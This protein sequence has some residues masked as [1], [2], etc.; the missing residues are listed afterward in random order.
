ML[1]RLL[2]SVV[3]KGA[4]GAYH[5]AMAKAAALR[6]GNPSASMVVIGVTGT[7]GK[8]TTAN[9]IA[10]V[11]EGAG[12]RVGL[13]TT[14]NFR[15]AGK[16]WLNDTKM[17]MLG[18]FRLQKLLAQMRDAGCR[19]AVIETSSEGIA[20]YRHAGIA[21]D[22]AVFTNLTPEHI[23]SHGGFENYK[24][25]KA[26]LFAKLSTDPRKSFDGKDVPKVI[27]SNLDSPHGQFF[28]DHTANKKYGYMVERRGLSPQGTVPQPDSLASPDSAAPRKIEWPIALVKAMSPEY[29]ADGARFN[30]RDVPFRLQMLG[31]IN[32]ENAM[33]A[34]AV[35]LSQGI[36]LPVMAKAL[37]EFK[38]VP[39]RQEFI[40]AGQ[41]FL[42]IVDYAHE[43]ESFRKLYDLI[44]LLPK[45][46]IIQ[47][48]GSAG[49]GRDKSR[50]TVLGTLAAQKADVVIVT[51]EDPYDEDP[52]AI[53]EAVA[54]GAREAGKRDGENLF[55][56]KDR[57]EALAAAVGMAQKDD[58][59]VATGKGA[60]QW[61]CVADGKKVP[62]DERVEM[63]K[64]IE[65]K[66][67]VRS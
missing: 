47:I 12:F 14:C 9:M 54:A 24:A 5:R 45:R 8:S 49:G 61:I 38:G 53:I 52:D 40:R 46:R 23:E 51:N 64:A 37:A 11:L 21:Y 2:K 62:W 41:D 35:G 6:Y 55:V 29:A 19:Y 39:G 65:A 33:A 27:V 36:E 3:P 60:E 30:V 63:R 42:A 22:M 59:V 58:I 44:G 13:A 18:R 26:K 10:A 25:A 48:I 17:T 31:V 57:R 4:L 7:N 16:E 43:P 20:Q 28:L 15:I 1:K 50:R 67:G 56:V 34:V 66:L 32:V